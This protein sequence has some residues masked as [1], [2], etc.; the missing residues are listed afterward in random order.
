M[1]PKAPPNA[2]KA[3]LYNSRNIRTHLSDSSFVDKEKLNVPDFLGSREFEIKSFE[4]S[5]LNSKYASSNRVFQ[6]LP[7]SL[8]RRAASHNVKRIPKRL[9]AKALREMKNSITGTP[10]KKKHSRGRALYKLN[11]SKKLLK[12]GNNLK[13]LGTLPDRELLGKKLNIRTKIKSLNKQ[14]RE[15]KSSTNSPLAINNKVGAYDNT[16]YGGYASRPMGNI[17]Y[18]K[19]QRQFVWLPTHIWHAK[20]FH[21]IKQYGYQIPLSPTQKCFRL[22]SRQSKNDSIAFDTSYYSSL[23]INIEDDDVFKE[24]LIFITKFHVAIPDKI[25]KGERA[26]N[27]WLYIEG[28]QI[29]KGFIFAH[30]ASHTIIIRTFPSIYKDIFN[31]CENFLMCSSG[32]NSIYDCQYSLGS[33]D[34][35]GPLSLLSLSKILHIYDEDKSSNIKKLWSVLTSVKDTKAIPIG[36]NFSFDIMDPRFWNKSS[37]TKHNNDSDL[38][39]YYDAIA[40]MNSTTFLDPTSVKNL[41]TREGRTKSYE[42]QMS[43]KDIGKEFGK[44]STRSRSLSPEI[45]KHSRI[46]ILLS[47]T[48]DQ[49][50]TLIVPWFWV[51]PIWQKLV[52]IKHVIPGGIKQMR[53]VNYENGKP[54]FPNDYP[55]LRDGWENNL[56]LDSLNRE[57]YYKLPKHLLNSSRPD[58]TDLELIS[59]FHCDWNFLR[60]ITL[61]QKFSGMSI[62]ELEKDNTYADYGEDLF[63]RQINS[64]HDLLQLSKDVRELHYYRLPTDI[65]I[66]LFDEELEFH[67]KFITGNYTINQ[68]RYVNIVSLPVIQISV[69][70][71]GKGRLRDGARI[72]LQ[73][74]DPYNYAAIVGFITSGGYNIQLGIAS[75]IGLVK[76]DISIK[77]STTLYIR[78]IGQT[79][80]YA[81]EA[82]IIKT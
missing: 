31:H 29:G 26:Y 79:S 8:R 64:G 38:D 12:L 67:Q 33:I 14:I 53:Q 58:F 66:S 32:L 35:V 37:R 21:M 45:L 39:A 52:K 62:E 71:V 20:R 3:R 46:P 7:R 10:P 13:L 18:H 30:I 76:A 73:E 50:W 27:D 69:K 36:F 74:T 23:I 65:S 59:P 2:K 82:I 40:S 19:R 22:M 49:S 70:L 43:I 47:K 78:N 57:K 55:W 5:Q 41:S 11:M 56:S 44:I 28:Q 72:Y 42:N 77:G 17:K 80:Y 68:A 4:L 24:L 61:L 51:L 25:L 9:R 1:P 34:L 16:G 48:G 6:S 60:T 75:G 54:N 81:A 63:I 15:L